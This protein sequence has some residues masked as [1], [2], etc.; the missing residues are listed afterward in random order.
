MEEVSWWP[1]CDRDV[2]LVVWRLYL[3][4]QRAHRRYRAPSC[5]YKLHSDSSAPGSWDLRSEAIEQGRFGGVVEG[6]SDYHSIQGLR[7]W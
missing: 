2:T 3:A 4:L 5:P 6:A 7:S 1:C